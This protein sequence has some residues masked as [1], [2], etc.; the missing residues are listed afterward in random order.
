MSTEVV[1]V[2][3]KYIRPQYKD[4]RAWCEDPR[5]VYIGRRGVIFIKNED[6]TKTRYPPRDSVFANPFKTGRDGSRSEVI[7]KYRSYLQ[8]AIDQGKITKEDLEAL[9]GKR[10]G[11]WCKPEACHGDVLVEMIENIS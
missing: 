7:A 1:N 11:C 8:T 10:L 3:V 4:L 6:N 9:R 2:R 5:N